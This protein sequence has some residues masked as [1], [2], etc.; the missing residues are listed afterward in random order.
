MTEATQCDHWNDSAGGG[1]RLRPL[2]CTREMGHDGLHLCGSTSWS[3]DLGFR[4]D[5]P[6]APDGE[7]EET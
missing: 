4:A 5:V 1:I 3:E 7:M 2:R 6:L